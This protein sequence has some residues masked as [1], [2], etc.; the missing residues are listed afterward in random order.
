MTK[1]IE[2]N[3][4]ASG[5]KFGIVVSRFNEFIS[6][7]LLG[8]SLDCLKR[9]DADME[10][11]DVAWVPGSFEIPLVAKKMA[12]SRKYDAVICL[13]TVIKGSTPHFDYV[14]AEVSKGISRINLDSDVPVIF[15]VITTDSIEQAIERAGTKSGN[16]GWDSALGAI[17]MA[18]LM[19]QFNID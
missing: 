15:G 11:V 7:K 6:S 8:G 3:L 12:F 5:K 19:S 10:S 1:I 14:C 9:H 17:E 2:G 13:G 4:T 16:K 18:S